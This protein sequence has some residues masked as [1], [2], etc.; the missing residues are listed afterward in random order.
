MKRISRYG[1]T[2]IELLVVIAIIAILAA[3]LFPVFAQARAA[4]RKATCI[5]NNKQAVLGLLM[6][7]QDYDETLPYC[8][9]NGDSSRPRI[10]WYDAIEPYVKVG[11]QLYASPPPGGFPRSQPTFWID[12]DFQNRSVPM[13]PGDPTPWV[14]ANSSYDP[15]RGY[16][17]NNNLMPYF[18]KTAPYPYNTFPALTYPGSVHSIAEINAPA[19]V[20]LIA[21]TLSSSAVG[22]DDWFSGCDTSGYDVNMPPGGA[23][24]AKGN[25][26]NYCGA[27]YR[28][29]G[30]AVY[31]LAD[32]HAKWFKGPS[33]SWRAPSTTN[34]AYMKSLAPNATAWFRED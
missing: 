7:V 10:D 24:P 21:H 31:A 9:N 22:G 16:A 12:P 17:A 32:G 27:R 11:A 14:K 4:A 8:S 13:A 6:Y 19:Q 20:V 26:G 25:P 29:N 1:F 30:G 15:S 18:Q 3:I 28:H 5:S 33:S 34:V 23:S 2:L